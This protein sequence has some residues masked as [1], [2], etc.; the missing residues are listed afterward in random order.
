MPIAEAE[1]T[2]LSATQPTDTKV[3]RVVRQLNAICKTAT[4][5]FAL[6][7]GKLIVDSFYSGDLA[8]W[9]SR[10]MKNVS[11]RRLANHPDLPMSATALYRSTAIYEVCQRAGASEWKHLST[12]HVRLVLPL[13]PNQQV[14]LLRQAEADG[15]PVQRLQEEIVALPSSGSAKR[16]G[17]KKRP[18]L[19]KALRTL[20]AFLDESRSL[21]S[22]NAAV[23]D[24]SPESAQSLVQLLHRVQFACT[25]LEQRVSG[26]LEK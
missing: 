6:S 4:F 5:H 2:N 18:R 10:G 9:R 23:A 17:R 11:F 14:R 15:W 7:V 1:T 8:A 21:L 13:A 26:R 12:S 24:L 20:Q 19:R 22:A 25:E 3:E 16:G